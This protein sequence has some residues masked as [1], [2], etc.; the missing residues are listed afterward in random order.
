M[1]RSLLF[2]IFPQGRR[3]IPEQPG[4]FLSLIFLKNSRAGFLTRYSRR[5]ERRERADERKRERR[6]WNNLYFFH[7]DNSLLV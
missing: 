1:E 7:I 6:A 2:W 5:D 3:G 4:N